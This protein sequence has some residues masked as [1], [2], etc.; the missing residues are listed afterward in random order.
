MRRQTA[1]L[2]APL[3]FAPG[4]ANALNCQVTL[5]PLAFGLYQPGTTIPLDAVANITVRCVAQPG[6][7]AVTIGPGISGNQLART[8][9]NGTG[10]MLN[11]NL[12]RDAGHSQVWGDGTPPTFT[13]TG[14]RTSVGQPTVNV[15]PLYGRVYPNQYPDPGTYSDS[16]LVTVLF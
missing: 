7:Y 9:L 11:Y 10:G 16:L 5:A 4:I 1:A 15:H 3:L 8:L 14:S 6:T 12:Y 13:V 2:L